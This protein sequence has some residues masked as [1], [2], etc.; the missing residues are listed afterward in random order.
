MVEDRS[1][2][3]GE[4]AGFQGD[5]VVDELAE[6]GVDGW[7][8]AVAGGRAGVDHGPA[9]LLEPGRGGGRL[10]QQVGLVVLEGGEQEV[11]VLQRRRAGHREAEI[12]LGGAA[13]QVV[14]GV[15][16]LLE[17]WHRSVG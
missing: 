11:K 1:I 16:D 10:G 12:D 3:V 14:L 13:G 15:A 9:K 2:V 4:G 7:D 6:V 8:G 5:V 17:G